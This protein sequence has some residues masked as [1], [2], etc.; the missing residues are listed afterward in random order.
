MTKKLLTI[1]EFASMGGKARAARRD[2]A[3]LSKIAA[4]GG[5]ARAAKYTTAELRAFAENAGRRPWK[6]TPKVRER[7]LAMLKQERDHTEIAK[8]FGV[9]LRTVGRIKADGSEGDRETDRL[10]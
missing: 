2:A 4:K 1:A 3:T 7:I 6:I 10:D 5:K 8:R 9:S